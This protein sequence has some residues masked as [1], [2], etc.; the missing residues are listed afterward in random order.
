MMKRLVWA[1]VAVFVVILLAVIIFDKPKPPAPA[2]SSVSFAYDKLPVLGDP[3]APIKIVEFGDYKCPSCQYFSQDIKTQL[4]K[5]YIDQGIVAFYFMN[6]PIIGPDSYTAAYAAQS[7]YHQNNDAFWKYYE[8]LYINQQD[9]K[10]NWATP[11]FLTELAQVKSLPINIDL[12]KQD[13]KSMK[14]KAEVDEQIAIADKSGVT[15]TPTLFINGQKFEE[16]FD[17]NALKAAIE[18]VRKNEK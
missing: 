17:Y 3:K 15:G 11:E 6:Y 1:T 10:N 7:V 2:A 13:I 5:E 9:E 4:Q 12:L 14:Y 8:T 16:V 18:K